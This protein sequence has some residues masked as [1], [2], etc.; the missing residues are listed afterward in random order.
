MTQ[1]V[2]RVYLRISIRFHDVIFHGVRIS[3]LMHLNLGGDEG[4]DV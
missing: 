2:K 3:Y 1:K 4:F